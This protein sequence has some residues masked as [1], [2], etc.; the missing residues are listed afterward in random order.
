[1]TNLTPSQIKERR[2]KRESVLADTTLKASALATLIRN[3]IDK[4]SYRRDNLIC[5]AMSL[6]E[7]ILKKASE[8]V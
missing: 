6:L 1:M 3:E 8:V 7:D 4:S 2:E 5:S